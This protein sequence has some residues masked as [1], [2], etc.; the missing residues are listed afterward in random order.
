VNAKDGKR[1]C[2]ISQLFKSINE[3]IG[4]H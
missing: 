4:Y 2:R 1:F 3:D